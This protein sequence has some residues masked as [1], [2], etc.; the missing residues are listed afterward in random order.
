MFTPE[1]QYNMGLLLFFPFLLLKIIL[2]FAVRT[3][4]RIAH[5]AALT[6]SPMN[7][8]AV[9]TVA[10]MDVVGATHTTPYRIG[11]TISSGDNS[12]RA[13]LTIP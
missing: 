1:T 13:M 8:F 2:T 10:A 9:A 6:L 7:S 4:A 5:L 3:V 11:G 12:C